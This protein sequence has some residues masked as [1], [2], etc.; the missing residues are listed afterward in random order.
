MRRLTTWIST[1]LLEI[2]FFSFLLRVS[3]ITGFAFVGL[4]NKFLG[5]TL[6]GWVNC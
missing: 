1:R 6:N 5:L 2:R 3:F 4:E